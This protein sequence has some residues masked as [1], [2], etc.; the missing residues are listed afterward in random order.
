MEKSVINSTDYQYLYRIM[1]D[2]TDGLIVI[3]SEGTI[4]YVNPSAKKILDNE[5]LVE[6]KKYIEFMVTDKTGENDEFHQYVLDCASEVNK[7]HEGILNYSCPDGS[8]HIFRVISS[9]AYNEERTQ[10]IGVILQFSDITEVQKA[11]RKHIEATVVLV[12]LLA[13]LS[14]WNLIFGIWEA[15]GRSLNSHILTVIIEVMGAVL[16]FFVYRSTSITKEDLGISFK[17]VGRAV[18][19]DSFCTAAVLVG[20]V[21]LKLIM[22]AFDPELASRPM[23]YFS[24]WSIME[25]VYPITVVVQEFLTR[26]VVQGSVKKILPGKHAVPISIIL[27]SMFFSALHIHLGLGFMVGSFLLLSVF[28]ILYEKQKTIWGLCIPHF[29][30]GLSLKLIWGIGA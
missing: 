6:G 29:F 14:V 5:A 21:I 18:A 17:G 27:S 23:F 30:L 2:I 7:D 15:R 8:K 11:R 3:D 13:M 19:V 25:T 10:S 16:S 9:Y 20:M 12:A 1:R 24:S 26:G 28:G 4:A 22:R